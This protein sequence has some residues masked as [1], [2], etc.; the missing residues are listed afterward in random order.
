MSPSRARTARPGADRGSATVLLLGWL[1]IL[2]VA[3]AV[4]LAVSAVS[5][6]RRQAAT[7]A[8]LAA[9]AA[10]ADR[11]GDPA[12]AC[13]RAR[14]FAARNG[15]DL[16]TCRAADGAV[17]VVARVDPPPALRMLGPL[18]AMSRAGPWIGTTSS[19]DAASPAGT[20]RSTDAP[21]WTDAPSPAGTT[22][23]SR[24]AGPIGTEAQR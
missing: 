1:L 23:P 19:T 10:A 22:D 5:L 17:E 8:D 24:P 2:G 9:L 15:V 14:L 3:A 16:V 4:L 11:T 18:A 20:G 6:A 7:G 13:G 21:S 12:A